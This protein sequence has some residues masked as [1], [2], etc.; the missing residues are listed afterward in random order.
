MK[1]LLTL[2]PITLLIFNILTSSYSDGPGTHSW[3]GTGATTGIPGCSDGSTGCHNT[4]VSTDIDV[5]VELDS[6][7]VSVST[8]SPGHDY[9]IRIR[10]V[11]RSAFTLPKFGFQLACVD[12]AGAGTPSAIDMGTWGATLPSGCINTT[13]SPITVIEHGRPL[14]PYSG[15]GAGSGATVYQEDIPWTAP[16]A[17]SGSVVI[18]G[19]VNAVNNDASAD[20]GDIYNGV[21]LTIDEGATSLPSITGASS[22]CVGDSILLSIATVGGSW[23]SS[24]TS[25]ATVSSA[26]IVRGVGVG[27]TTITYTLGSVYTTH[28]V[29][30]LSSPSAGTI[31]GPTHVCTGSTI[32]LSTTGSGGV[33]SGGAP[34]ASITSTGVV[35]G[36]SAG[37]ANFTYSVTTSCGTASAYYSDTVISRPRA[38]MITGPTSICASGTGSFFDSTSG[39]TW[40]S[41]VTSVATIT[42][43]GVAH[44][45]SVG[46]DSIRY[47]VSSSGCSDT[48]RFTFAVVTPASAGIIRSTSDTVCTGATLRYYDTTYTGGVAT[49]RSSATSIATVDSITGII[50]GVYAGSAS[51]TCNVTNGCGTASTSK[52]VYVLPSRTVGAIS[53][54]HSICG[55]SS[56]TITDTSFGGSWSVSDASIA[57]IVAVGGS[58]VVTGVS[59]GTV[60]VSYTLP[61]TRCGSAVAIDTIVVTSGTG[62]GTISGPSVVCSGSPATYTETSSGGT[63]SLAF[64]TAATI[65]SGGVVTASGASSDSVIYT[66]TGS[67][68]TLHAAYPITTATSPSAGAVTGTTSVCLTTSPTYIIVGASGTGTWSTSSSSVATIGSTTGTLSTVS[69][70]T[71]TVIYTVTSASCGTARAVLPITVIAAPSAG[72]ISGP[73][74]VCTGSTIS[75]STT[76]TG[77]SWSSV[78]TSMA[79]VDASGVV[80]GVLAG[81][82]TI[83]YTVTGACGTSVARYVVTVNASPSA[84]RI[85]GF[86]N[87]CTGSSFAMLDGTASGTGTWSSSASSIATINS[88]TGLGGGVAAGSAIISYTVTSGSCGSATDTFIVNVSTT[89]TGGSITGASTY[90][91]GTSATLTNSTGTSGGTWSIVPSTAATVN[92]STGDIT[93]NTSGTATISYTVTSASCGSAYATLPVTINRSPN[94]GSISGSSSVCIGAT[95]TMTSSGDAGGTWVSGSTS[96]AT[97][98]SSGGVARG[99][100][101]GASI[102]SYIT[103]S[104]SCGDDTA[105]FTLTVNPISSAGTIT[106]SSTVC[107]TASTTLSEAVAGG[108]WSSSSSARATVDASGT[109]Y[110]VSAGAVTITYSVSICGSAS[111]T[112]DMTILPMPTAGSISGTA[113]VCAGSSVTLTDG[114]TGGTWSSSD[115]SI[116]TVS[117]TG[118]VTGT[119]GGSATI[120]YTVSNSCGSV[121]ATYPMTGIAL[122]DTGVISGPSSICISSPATLSET[123]TGGTWISGTTSVATVSSTGLVTGLTTGSTI[124]SYQQSN[125]C[126]TYY[127]TFPV[128]ITTTPSAGTILGASVVCEGASITLS[129]ATTGGTWSSSS[130]GTATVDASGNVFGVAGGSVDISYSITGSCGTA[131]TYSTITVNP[132]PVTGTI[133]GLSTICESSSTLLS[134]TVSGGTWSSMTTSIATVDAFGNVYGVAAGTDSIFYSVT[135]S[136][137]T[138]HAGFNITIE[139]PVSVAAISG[140]TTLCTGATTSYTDA[141]T[142]GSWSS[143]TTSIATVNASGIVGGV[144]SGTS[145]ISY[146]V[147]NTCGVYA[148]SQIITVNSTPSAGSIS[149]P[150]SV[151]QGA[152]I[153]LSETTTG[154]TWSSSNT[155]ISTV[156]ASGNVYGV[157]GGS[158]NISYTVTASCGTASATYAVT[159]N[160]LPNAGTISGSSTGCTSATVTLSETATGGT[161]SSSST[162]VAS[163]DASGVVAC[164]SNGSVTISYTVTNSC[165]TATATY[166]MTV[167]TAPSSSSIAAITGPSTGCAGSSITLS[168]TTTGGTWSSATTSVA[169][170][171]GSGNVTCLTTGTTNISYTLTNACGSAGVGY[172]VTVSTTP[173]LGSISGPSFVCTGSTITLTNSTSGGTWSSSASSVA[174]VDPTTGVVSGLVAGSATITY[175]ITGACGSAAVIRA[176]TVY[177]ATDAGYITGISTVCP[178]STATLGETVTGG[179]WSSS[180]TSV[181]TVSSAGVVY[182]LSGGTTIISYS[183][184]GVCGTSHATMTFTVNPSPFAGVISGPASVCVGDTITLTDTTAGGVW[185]TGNAAIASVTTTGSVIGVSTGTVNIVYAVTNVCGTV[186]AART[187]TVNSYPYPGV[188]SGETRVCVGSPTLLSETVSGG[189]WRVSNT[190][191]SISTGGV[192]RGLSMGIDTVYYDVTNGCGTTSATY[193]DSIYGSF[194][195]GVLGPNDTMC[196]GDTSYLTAPVPFGAWSAYNSNVTVSAD[197]MIIAANSGWDT[198]LYAV[199]GPC[200]V[201]FGIYYVWVKPASLCGTAIATIEN[202]GTFEVY[203]NPTTGMFNVKVPA[204]ETNV[205]VTI[206]DL[207]GHTVMTQ[208][209]ENNKGNEISIQLDNLTSGTYMVQVQA[210]TAVFHQKIVLER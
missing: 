143:T 185:G 68:G 110:G 163:V 165:G 81:T 4:A 26:G 119:G 48:A 173:T 11:N 105:F 95:T 205:Q 169:T 24:T 134:P 2:L 176:I 160:P 46:I 137:G 123:A 25:V 61:S 98:T 50:T 138:R 71:D 170:V 85:T 124:I 16:S 29:S 149:G 187:I 28:T 62:S 57:T 112:F 51:I 182:G 30:V 192:L 183:V 53:G 18:F 109:V 104:A 193:Y 20:T 13:I 113:S 178:G 75:L 172:P 199:S 171:D 87:T 99:V 139:A 70:G 67:C 93:F 82:D 144:A 17:G 34:F 102:L 197:G 181:A 60:Y 80:T 89:P 148:A 91:T 161:W 145:T 136:C 117:S 92:S 202:T 78:F 59:A 184:T 97:I 21:S 43:T 147:T 154:G 180:A 49:W 37:V 133:G 141:T 135:N 88:T 210:G 83:K 39:G 114:T 23:S 74:S 6:A 32:S 209:V 146:T 52:T 1:K 188:I 190:H 198:V 189:T 162:S 128:T 177:T 8:Y 151:C 175:S 186:S 111:T 191:A 7:G 36:I 150:S 120:S 27:T 86:H 77:G 152:S 158:I 156:D 121:S 5:T 201:Q 126:G 140:A 107:A 155:A 168:E 157:A 204:N 208:A 3:E 131:S 101:A 14:D 90:C 118:V 194:S 72:T 115:V 33:W 35:T 42:S 22:V 47:I 206:T 153:S 203:P 195:S 166:P 207:L 15:S 129:D 108:T 200:G 164:I 73:S 65:T 116:V 45:V 106:G 19:T 96:I 159:V 167:I 130:T 179:T 10:A 122:P 54:G 56:I 9:T 79:T 38:S 40:V 132:L 103:T 63:W 100:A 142:G 64:G 41:M 127:A 58:C 196:V 94:S 55:T 125:S 31:S 66:V 174:S 76:G 84:G 12:A 44:A 69:A